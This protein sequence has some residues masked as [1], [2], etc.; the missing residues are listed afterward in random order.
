MIATKGWL[1]VWAMGEMLM[2]LFL[3]GCASLRSSPLLPIDFSAEPPRAAIRGVCDGESFTTQG[4]V[5]CEQKEPTPANISVKVP[6]TEGRV[7]YSNG[8]LKRTDDFNWYPKAGFWIWKK[9]PIKDTWV[10][11]D[12][13]EIASVFGDWPVALDVVANSDAG[14]I[15][16]RGVIYYRVCNDKDIPCSSLAV[17]YE[18][19]GHAKSTAPGQI[20]KCERMSG[21]AE[22]FI[23]NLKDA[24]PGAK[25]YFVARRLGLKQSITITDADLGSGLKKLET[26]PLPSGPTLVDFALDWWDGNTLKHEETRVLVVGFDP[27]WTGLD[28]PHFL[29]R[30]D[31]LDWVKPVF[32]DIME[33]NVYRGRD[34][35][36]KKF[37]AGKVISAGKPGQGEV[38]CAYAWQ[39]DAADLS[40]ECLDQNLNEVTIP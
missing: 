35:K 28:Q 16:T 23:V 33:T 12:L 24:K 32:S 4:T 37:G 6:P 9:K 17:Q 11:L 31:H 40:I 34:M 27:N 30:G 7:I 21:S 39:R 22:D 15:D 36:E 8:Q 10:D 3:S 18:C 20:G 14:I 19:A 13:G 1:K 29:D 25:L 5:V 2:A 26:P 38:A